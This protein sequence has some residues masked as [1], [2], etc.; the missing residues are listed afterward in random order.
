MIG[1]LTIGAIALL[2]LRKKRGVSGIGAPYKRKIYQELA[3]I[4]RLADFSLPYEDQSDF[5]KKT[6]IANCNMI[7][8]KYPKRKP[9]TVERYYKQLKRAYN[10]IS[11]IG[12]TSLPYF[13][14][15]IRNERG[16]I[17]LIHRDY[18]SEDEFLWNACEWVADNYETNSFEIGY[19]ETIIAI[20]LGKRFVWKSSGVHRG[21]EALVFGKSAPSERKARISYLA[22][23]DKGGV[24]PEKFAHTIWES[25]NSTADDQEILDGVLHAIRTTQ[26]ATQAKTWI[27]D[28]YER[29]HIV[30]E[31][32]QEYLDVP[33]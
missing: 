24:Y 28:R 14:S 30:E 13:E 6:L 16:D 19:W 23:P 4:N 2:A 8:S 3:A 15:T 33:F 17:I 7:N 32:E 1:L 9:I 21:V 20:A 11:G 10:A 5:V 25:T 29:D 18:G 26:S 31:N 12:E 27:T 22:S